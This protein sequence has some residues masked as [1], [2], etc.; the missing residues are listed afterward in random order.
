MKVVRPKQEA[1]SK[2]RS[3]YQIVKKGLDEKEAELRNVEAK[4]K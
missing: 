1:L 2:A 3:E 4:L